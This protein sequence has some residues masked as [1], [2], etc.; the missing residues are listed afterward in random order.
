MNAHADLN[1]LPAFLD[2]R[3][4]VYTFTNLQAYRNCA[5]A[6]FRRYLKKDIPYI[7]TPE[8]KW[9][10]D[11]HTAFER[12]VG[13]RQPLPENMQQ[14]EA[15]AAP[16]DGRIVSV[17]QKLGITAKGQPTGFWDSD[18]WFR[19]KV[20]VAVL[21]NDKAF[22]NDWKTGKSN[23]EDPFEL[24]TGALLLKAKYP[25]LT[26]IKGNYTWLKEN[27]VG[28]PYDLS[29]FRA[30]W[31]EIN[32]L[33]GKIEADRVSGEFEK[34]RSGLCGYCDVA[35]CENQYVAKKK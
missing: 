26:A 21:S 5:H 25:E 35:D 3:K 11:V 24:E 16:F 29:R 28:Q 17:E 34:Q 14:W 15:F 23:Y 6:M 2:R 1:E 8:M 32:R 18:C 20:D 10:N 4:I 31:D 9:G 22:I 19:G 12:R 7:E 30:T 27:R 13:S 33:V